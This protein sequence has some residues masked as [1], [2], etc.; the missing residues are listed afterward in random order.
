MSTTPDHKQ[1][2]F[3]GQEYLRDAGELREQINMFGRLRLMSLIISLDS[4]D[5]QIETESR[6]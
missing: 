4:R 5:D 3:A 6:I 2:G 1:K